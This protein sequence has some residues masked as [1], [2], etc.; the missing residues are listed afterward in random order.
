MRPRLP[1]RARAFSGSAPPQRDRVSVYPTL[2]IPYPLYPMAA[3]RRRLRVVYRLVG[4]V[5]LMGVLRRGGCVLRLLRLLDAAT[6]LLVAA[7]RTVDV[8]P[9]KLARR[10]PEVRAGPGLGGGWPWLYPPA[11]LRP[12]RPCRAMQPRGGRWGRGRGKQLRRRSSICR[13]LQSCAHRSV[14]MC[15]GQPRSS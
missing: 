14:G 12:G 5:L 4:G 10:Y 3:A 9:D 7:A 15:M 8:T 2:S 1:V 13:M 6:R 11:R